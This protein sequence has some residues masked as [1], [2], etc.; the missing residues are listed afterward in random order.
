[1]SASYSKDLFYIQS[2]D[3][4]RTLMSA[5]SNLAGLFPPTTAQVWNSDMPWQPIPVHTI[6]E[7][8]D[9]ILAAKRPCPLYDFTLKE[10]KRS[11]EY[12]KLNKH[13]KSLYNYLTIHSGKKIDSF[14]AVNNLYNVLFIENLYNLT[15]PKWTRKIFPEGDMKQISGRSFATKTNTKKL[16]RLKVGFLLKDIFARFSNVTESTLSPNRKMWIYSGHDTT[17]GNVLNALGLFEYHTPPYAAC[18]MFELRIKKGIPYVQIFY[19]NT[20]DLYPPALHIPNCGQLCPLKDLY[21]LYSSILP[22]EDFDNEC[23]LYSLTMT[24]GDGVPKG[25]STG[26]YRNLFYDRFQ[27]NVQTKHKHRVDC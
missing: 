11:K 1:M 24:Y 23:K 21:R 5:L 3:V 10:Y 19:R 2:T 27:P 22:T 9:H 18:I 20:T 13:Y 14:T 26:K 17:I 16:A 7:K 4:D 8:L 15:L 25:S 6:P 12:R